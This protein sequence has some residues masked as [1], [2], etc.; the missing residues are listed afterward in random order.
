[1]TSPRL[2]KL[3]ENN[4]YAVAFLSRLLSISLGKLYRQTLERV[5][6]TPHRVKS[7]AFAP[8]THF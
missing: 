7:E 5:I 3:L 4:L 2:Q 6:D 8:V 1:M